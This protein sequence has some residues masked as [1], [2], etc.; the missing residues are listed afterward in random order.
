MPLNAS[1]V[2]KRWANR[3]AGAGE[4]I[5]AGVQA[6]QESPTAKAAR[7][8]DRYQA[9]VA[10]AVSSGRMRQRLESVSTGEWQA[11]MVN[12]GLPRIA[13][14]ATAAQQKVERF[15]A[16]FLPHV[17][18]GKAMV[19]SMPKGSVEDGIA[20]AAAMIRHNASFRKRS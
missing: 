18:A 5:R 12:K 4:K 15:L 1:D 2:A 19:A 11:A 17:E 3:L 14:G 6:V 13:P 16:E 7:N 10:E 9:G 20:R 8:L